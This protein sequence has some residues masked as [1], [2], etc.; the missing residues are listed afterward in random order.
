VYVDS[1]LERAI[2]VFV[3]EQKNRH[4]QLY[5]YVT[6][7]SAVVQPIASKVVTTLKTKLR[8][9]YCKKKESGLV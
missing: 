1:V 9:C 3:K 2:S 6:S 7:S 5:M 8:T 4:S